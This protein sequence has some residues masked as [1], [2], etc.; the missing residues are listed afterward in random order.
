V[1]L[2]SGIAGAPPYSSTQ[3]CL[4]LLPVVTPAAKRNN[5]RRT[6]HNPSFCESSRRW[7]TL[8]QPGDDAVSGQRPAQANGGDHHDERGHQSVQNK[9]LKQWFADRRNGLA[10]LGADRKRQRTSNSGSPRIA[11][12]HPKPHTS[13][14]EYFLSGGAQGRDALSDSL[15][16]DFL[17]L[18]QTTLNNVCQCCYTIAP[19]DH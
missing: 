12:H 10:S 11:V 5:P 7:P 17:E 9:Q 13:I 16:I 8:M 18:F 2:L 15:A 1:E 14:M 6:F 3:R 19:C 4:Q